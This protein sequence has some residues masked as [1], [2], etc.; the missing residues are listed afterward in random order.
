[1]PDVV[2][3]YQ[4][5]DL[6]R[7]AKP[8]DVAVFAERRHERLDVVPLDVPD[9]AED[10]V[11]PWPGW[12]ERGAHRYVL[13]LGRYRRRQR[14]PRIQSGNRALRIHLGQTNAV[15]ACR[16]RRSSPVEYTGRSG[17]VLRQKPDSTRP[18]PT[19][20]NWST[21]SATSRWSV[22]LQR[23]EP[24]SCRRSA[25]TTDSASWTYPA[26]T[27]VTSGSFGSW[28]VTRASSAAYSSS[29]SRISEQW[30]G[31]PTSRTTTRSA[32]SAFAAAAN[33]VTAP[34]VPDTTTWLGSL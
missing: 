7:A 16:S 20:T 6:Q 3:V 12:C 5:V 34:A 25:S 33:R 13:L 29:T 19:S 23:T 32:P 18:G 15:R 24:A 11:A 31:A 4:Q 9:A 21:P 14:C 27:F 30:N 22:S 28:N 1:M 2:R 26:V 10:Q 8:D 17:Q